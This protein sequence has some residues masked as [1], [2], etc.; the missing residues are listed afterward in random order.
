[1]FKRNLLIVVAGII[2]LILASHFLFKQEGKYKS[3]SSSANEK[4]ISINGV[5]LLVDI[6]DTPEEQ[7][8][9]LSGRDKMAENKGMLFVFPVSNIPGFWMKDMRFSLDFIWIAESGMIVDITENITPESYPEIFR[10]SSPVKYVL[11]VNA[12]WVDRNKVKVGDKVS[13]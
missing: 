13:F 1:M 11:E 4:N 12:G 3:D 9:G 6:A 10:S 5:D 2:V 8:Q 7:A